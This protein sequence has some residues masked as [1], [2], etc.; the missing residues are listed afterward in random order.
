MKNSP[1]PQAKITAAL[2]IRNSQLSTELSQRLDE[3]GIS[4]VFEDGPEP[5]G[6]RYCMNS[7][8]LTLKADEER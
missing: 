6:L 5:T 7:A 8:A 3:L 1:I 2:A 4:H